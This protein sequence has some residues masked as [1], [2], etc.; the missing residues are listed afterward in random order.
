MKTT[1][2]MTKMK[3][4]KKSLNSFESKYDLGYDSNSDSFLVSDSDSS[5]SKTKKIPHTQKKMKYKQ[6]T[7]H[8]QNPHPF[9]QQYNHPNG[10]PFASARAPSN[11]FSYHQKR[12]TYPKKMHQFHQQ[13]PQPYL[14]LPSPPQPPL[15]TVPYPNRNPIQ[16]HPYPQEMHHYQHQNQHS[17][18][19][20]CPSNY[21][22]RDSYKTSSGKCSPSRCVR[23]SGLLRGK[24]KERAQRS[25]KKSK[26]RSEKALRMSKKR[27]LHIDRRCSKGQVLRKGYTRKSYNRKLGTKSHYRHALVAPRCITKRGKST[28]IHGEPS[29]KIYIDEDDH[30]LS[31]YGYHDVEMK[32]YEERHQAL[33]KLIHHFIPIKGEMA[34]YNYVIKALNARYILNKNTN[35]KVA[36][37]FK[38]DQRDISSEYKKMKH[39]HDTK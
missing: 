31:E 28:R 20:T 5:F 17:L 22:L 27:G 18:K 11:P 4:Y 25:F 29:T 13:Y 21:T 32:S 16:M 8:Y 34:T 6:K 7:M 2:K 19:P 10:N 12:K 9:P 35:P 1:K 24:S 14:R 15:F 26:E 39:N 38:L 36:R 30:Y 37:I 23:K 3:E 33:H